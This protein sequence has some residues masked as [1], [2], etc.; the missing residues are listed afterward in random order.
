MSSNVIGD[1]ET[2]LK[3]FYNGDNGMTKKLSTQQEHDII[4]SLYRC[5]NGTYYLDY[6][7]QGLGGAFEASFNGTENLLYCDLKTVFI[8]LKT[9]P[10]LLLHGE[11]SDILT[12][13]CVM[14][15]KALLPH[16]DYYK[17]SDRGHVLYFNEPDVIAVCDDFLK[18]LSAS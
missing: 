17:V 11:N 16:I 2:A 13:I 15:T 6:D 4:H 8:A 12:D 1:Y 3:T 5:D 14:D 18:H 9:I 7:Y 10:T